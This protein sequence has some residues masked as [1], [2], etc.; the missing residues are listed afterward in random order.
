M[1]EKILL[2][3]SDVDKLNEELKY[4][5]EVKKP[6]IIKQLQE[7]REQGDLSENADYDAAKTEQGNIEKRILEINE[8]LK[9]YELISESKTKKDRV[10]ILSTV[11]FIELDTKKEQEIK[12][13]GSEGNPSECEISHEAP[14]S[15]ALLGKKVGDIVEIRGI[16]NPYQIKI[17]S[18]R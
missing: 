12:I 4:L 16:E 8:L 9:N 13:V 1:T 18:I 6:N 17:T 10:S 5:I 7:A 14:L 3:Q 11:S 2:T 15:K